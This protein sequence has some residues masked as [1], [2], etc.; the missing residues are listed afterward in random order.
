MGLHWG[1]NVKFTRVHIAVFLGLSTLAWL[2][3]LLCQ[4]VNVSR[5]HLTPFGTVLSVL[6]VAALLLEHVLWRVKFFQPWFVSRPDLTGTWR[7]ELQSDYSDPQTGT[8]IPVI[9]CYMGVKQ[10]LSKLQMHLMTPESESWFIAERITPSPSDQGYQVV[11]VY[12]NKPQIHLRGSKSD[13]H[14][15]ALVLY[16][17]GAPH[18]PT[19]ITGEYWTD[20]STSGSMTFSDRLTKVYTR[21]NDAHAAS[22][23]HVLTRNAQQS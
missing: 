1:A 10:T 17:H 13:I 6:V 20:R 19:T 16:T 9:V 5:E 14:H 7:V 3:T 12:T 11:G 23:P 2:L 4:G 22:G 15:G 21:Y 8:P 18:R